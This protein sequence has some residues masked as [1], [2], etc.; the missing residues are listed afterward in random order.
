MLVVVLSITQVLIV[1]AQQVMIISQ[2]QINRTLRWE[3]AFDREVRNA[4]ADLQP[5]QIVL[6]ADL[7]LRLRG[8]SSRTQYA[9]E[10]VLVPEINSRGRL[11]WTTESVTANGE[12]ASDR[13]TRLIDAKV[14]VGWL[15]WADDFRV[16]RQ[17]SAVEVTDTELIITS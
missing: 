4:E 14:T 16:P 10:V 11:T 7:D 1:S 8:Q 2:D 5:G 12:P 17:V 9:V 3:F 13:L 6:T 15:D